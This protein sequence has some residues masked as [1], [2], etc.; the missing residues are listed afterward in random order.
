[1]CLEHKWCGRDITPEWRL[2]SGTRISS[3]D[4]DP[5][6]GE[7]HGPT[8]DDMTY[9]DFANDWINYVSDEDLQQM[10]DAGLF[11]TDWTYYR[12]LR[13]LGDQRDD[14]Q[15]REVARFRTVVE[16]GGWTTN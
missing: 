15:R 4:P 14:D 9:E 12:D 10:R 11:T 3:I 2:S 1:M 6:N 7:Y 8:E 13:D 5:E 16:I